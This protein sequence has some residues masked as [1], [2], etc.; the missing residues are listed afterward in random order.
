M[1]IIRIHERCAKPKRKPGWQQKQVEYEA[2]LKGVC[3]MP[4]G[5]KPRTLTFVR[6]VPVTTPQEVGARAARYTVGGATKP[7]SRPELLYRDNPELLAREL[8]AR[9]RKFTTAPAYNKGGDVLITDELMK[10]IMTGATRRR[11]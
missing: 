5:I 11:N 9:E 8:K 7:V 6:K 2:W 3:T 10:D 1:G 4:S